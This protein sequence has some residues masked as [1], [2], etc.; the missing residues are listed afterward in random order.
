MDGFH[1][2][3][4]DWLTDDDLTE[5]HSAFLE[6]GKSL[7]ECADQYR[8]FCKRYKPRKKLPRPNTRGRRILEK[9]Q[10][11]RLRRNKPSL[12]QLSLPGIRYQALTSSELSKV[13]ETFI[14]INRGSYAV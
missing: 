6:L 11:T 2:N 5:W 4:Y 13:A 10:L 8:R 12:D 3:L 14:L 1:V 9:I 7:D